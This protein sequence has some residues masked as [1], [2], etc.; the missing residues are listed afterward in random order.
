MTVYIT[1]DKHGDKLAYKYAIDQ[2]ENPKEEDIIIVCGDAS[3]EYGNYT[4]GSCRKVMSEFP[5]TW[6]IMRGNH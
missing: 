5:G 6:L 1:G 4:M 2:I 3:L